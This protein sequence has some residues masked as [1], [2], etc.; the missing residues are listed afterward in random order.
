MKTLETKLGEVREWL[1]TGTLNIFGKPFA[2]KDEQAKRLAP[3]LG[4]PI[5]GGGEILRNSRERMSPAIQTIMDEGGL[6]PSEDYARIVIPYLSNPDFSGKPLVF[7]AVGRMSG[8]EFGV[9]AAAD[10]AGHPI[11]AVPYLEITEAEAFRRLAETR[12][13]GRAD[14]TPERLRVRLDTFQT[15]TEPV[16]TTYE[17]MGLLVRVDAM[18][19]EAVVFNSL[20][21][22]LHERA[23][24]A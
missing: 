14:D 3:L 1:G 8:E 17:N 15:E 2:G 20:V 22:L 23:R 13:R 10:A 7:S 16:I 5:L 21:H 9:L 18:D 19:E 6:I 24:A 4:A 11:K 12:D